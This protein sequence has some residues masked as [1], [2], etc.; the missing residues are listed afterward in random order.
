MSI[1][2]YEVLSEAA[3]LLSEDDGNPEYDR[4]IIELATRLL[5]LSHDQHAWVAQVLRV[6]RGLS[7]IG[8]GQQ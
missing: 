2:H 8:R 5:G 4:A 3:D 6:L 1:K 7:G